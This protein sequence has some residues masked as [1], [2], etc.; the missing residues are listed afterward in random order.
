MNLSSLIKTQEGRIELIS[1]ITTRD[2]YDKKEST[3]KGEYWQCVP[4]PMSIVNKMVDKVESLE[5]REILV[6]FNPEFLEALIMDRGIDG[7]SVTLLADN[8]VM[9]E[10]AERVYGVETLLLTKENHNVK[11]LVEL[12]GTKKYDLV[13]SNPPYNKSIDIKILKEVVPL[14]RELVVVHP[15]TYLIDLK[16]K[17]KVFNEY[18]DLINGKLK[19]A[20]LFNGNP[21]F[22]IGLFVPTVIAHI[23]TDHDGDCAVTFFGEDYKASDVYGITKYGKDWK[24][25]AEPFMRDILTY[26]KGHKSVWDKN[27]TVP[28]EDPT[29]FYCQLGGAIGNW[30]NSNECMYNDDFYSPL[31]RDSDR[32]K[33]VRKLTTRSD[34]IISFSFKT[35]KERDNFIGYLKTDFARF[36]ISLFKNKIHLYAGELTTVPWLDFKECWDDEKLFKKFN[37]NKETQDF[38]RKY[39]P[40]YYDIRKSK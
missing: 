28:K 22:N 7:S 32:N 17:T 30:N 9:K 11:G 26:I 6:M 36:C 13:F 5:G 23:D 19:S 16:M 3:Y 20:E 15:S 21:I 34:G 38:I 39:I 35:E 37:V 40:D 14:C 1:A 8:E 10:M 2:Y 24:T 12:M 31:M 27:E 18:R 25:I 29:L 33:G 4:T